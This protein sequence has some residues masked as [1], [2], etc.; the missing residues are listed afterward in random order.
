MI[1]YF[2]VTVLVI[3]IINIIYIYIV[4][5]NKFLLIFS[6]MVICI[7]IL[8]FISPII[9]HFFYIEKNIKEI[10]Y[11]NL[12]LMIITHIFILSIIIL[13]IHYFI[14]E[15]FLKY[16]KINRHGRYIKLITDLVITISLI[17]LQR[18]LLYKIEYLSKSHPIRSKLIQ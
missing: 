16:F 12:Y 7:T 3:M 17:G 13:F 9:D 11:I 8:M 6:L 14:I 1:W 2:Q 18:N 5:M 4:Y 10:D 15:K